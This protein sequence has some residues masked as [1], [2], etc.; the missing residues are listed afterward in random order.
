MTSNQFIYLPKDSKRWEKIHNLKDNEFISVT[1]LLEF[2]GQGY[3]G[4]DY[5]FNPKKIAKR[6]EKPNTYLEYLYK[7]GQKNEEKAKEIFKKRLSFLYTL[8]PDDS[9]KDVC[10]SSPNGLIGTV[11]GIVMDTETMEPGIIEIKCPVGSRYGKSQKTEDRFEEN[12]NRWKHWLQLQLYLH[13]YQFSF[14]LLCYFYPYGGEEDDGDP[15]LIVTRVKRE[16]NIA[17]IVELD[18][19]LSLFFDDYRKRTT[20]IPEKRTKKNNC[21]NYNLIFTGITQRLRL[22]GSEIETK[23]CMLFAQE[24]Y[25]QKQLI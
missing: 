7:H 17:E 19:N 14:G 13:L 9:F 6:E 1:G 24:E 2:I 18:K 12:P 20:Y 16:E 21:L 4:R 25:Q 11:D 10:M 5:Y 23:G 15:V 22:R 3:N 8:I